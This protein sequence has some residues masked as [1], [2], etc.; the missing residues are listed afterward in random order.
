MDMESAGR[1]KSLTDLSTFERTLLAAVYVEGMDPGR[2]AVAADTRD[3]LC[4]A[5]TDLNCLPAID[6]YF[7]CLT[8]LTGEADET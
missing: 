2:L 4:V 8:V 1:L 6:A 5:L 7:Y 3:R